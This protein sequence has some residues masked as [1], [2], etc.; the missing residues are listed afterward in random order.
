MT[1][2]KILLTL[3]ILGFIAAWYIMKKIKDSLR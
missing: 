3:V 2:T 1:A